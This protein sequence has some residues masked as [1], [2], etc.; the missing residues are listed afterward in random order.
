MTPRR[1]LESERC[2]RCL[3]P[4]R[5]APARSK[6]SPRKAP[7]T[8]VRQQQRRRVHTE[9]MSARGTGSPQSSRKVLVKTTFHPAHPHEVCVVVQPPRNVGAIKTPR[10]HHNSDLE[11][12]TICLRDF[13]HSSATAAVGDSKKGYVCAENYLASSINTIAE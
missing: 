12:G 2:S 8:C 11:G 1:A 9:D 6:G 10:P 3:R 5:R 7:G 13:T 4:S